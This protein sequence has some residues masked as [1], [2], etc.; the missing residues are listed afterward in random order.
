MGMRSW[1][2]AFRRYQHRVIGASLV[3]AGAL[4]GSVWLF[5]HHPPEGVVRYLVAV[6]PALPLVGIIAAMGFFLKEE[7]DEFQRALMV[8]QMLWSMGATLSIATVWGFLESFG[9][10]PHV[11]AYYV[12]VLWFAAMGAARALVWWRYR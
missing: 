11:D 1:T 7:D 3:Y 10:A 5:K 8:E 9:V 12:A 4:L 6:A 2:P